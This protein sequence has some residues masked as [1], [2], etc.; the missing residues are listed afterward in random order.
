MVNGNHIWPSQPLSIRATWWTVERYGAETGGAKSATISTSNGEA[1]PQFSRRWL[2]RQ[3]IVD[4]KKFFGPECLGFILRQ[5][6]AR[7]T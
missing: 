2:L 3:N 5:L 6:E 4:I 1:R 7:S